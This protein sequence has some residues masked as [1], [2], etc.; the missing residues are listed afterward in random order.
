MIISIQTEDGQ[1]FIIKVGEG[2]GGLA[3]ATADCNKKHQPPLE[4]FTIEETQA[5][6]GAINVAI[7]IAMDERDYLEKSNGY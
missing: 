1:D 6:V 5:I 7:K 2:N 3:M 4:H